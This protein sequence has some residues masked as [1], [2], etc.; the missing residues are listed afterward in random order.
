MKKSLLFMVMLMMSVMAF[1]KDYK[2]VAFTTTPQMHCA[3]C[4]NKIKGNLR[5]SKGVKEI[6]T[7]I[8]DQKVTVTYDPKKTSPEKLSK[9]FEKFGYKA[10]VL[11]DGEKVKANKDEKCDLM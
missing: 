6:K 11:K 7:S 2:T 9:D 10:R 3:N 4:E 5:F 8:P 1:A